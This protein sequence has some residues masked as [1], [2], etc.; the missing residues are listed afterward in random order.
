[1]PK[2]PNDIYNATEGD[3]SDSLDFSND[4]VPIVSP[5]PLPSN[6]SSKSLNFSEDEAPT[7]NPS[8]QKLKDDAFI[9]LARRYKAKTSPKPEPE[10]PSNQTTI[11]DIMNKLRGAPTDQELLDAQQQARTNR[12]VAQLGLASAA[13]MRSAFGG[14]DRQARV[15]DSAWKSLADS[16][17]TPVDEYKARQQDKDYKLKREKELREIAFEQLKDDPDSDYSNFARSIIKKLAP[18]FQLSNKISASMLEKHFPWIEKIWDGN[19]K[20]LQREAD[21]AKSKQD[22]ADKEKEAWID[23]TTNKL[24]KHKAFEHYQ[25]AETGYE[26]A[27][28]AAENVSS[29]GDISTIFTFMKIN[30]PASVVRESEYAT[31]AKASGLL[32]AME[33]KFDKFSKGTILQPAQRQLLVKIVGAIRDK[34][35]DRYDEVRRPYY[36]KAERLGVDPERFDSYADSYKQGKAST[37]GQHAPGDIVE[38]QG[39]KYQVQEDGDSL[40]EF[41]GKQ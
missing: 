8:E 28:Y 24:N 12:M 18:D 13:G 34:L 19:Q 40:K 38:I 39:K 9:D 35:K 2:N 41:K 6:I 29:Y 21:L 16:A 3:L 5:Q 30:D 36:K 23:S 37:T 4:E 27:K 14:A 1:M 22:K 26:K 31:A 33:N 32:D 15:D 10:V 7:I 25:D 11:A 17:N 20:R